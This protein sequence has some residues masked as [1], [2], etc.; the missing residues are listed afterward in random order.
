[1]L[2]SKAGIPNPSSYKTHSVNQVAF[3]FG[4]AGRAIL[5][6]VFDSEVSKLRPSFN[7]LITTS[8]VRFKP[9]RWR[10]PWFAKVFIM[11]HGPRAV[12]VVSTPSGQHSISIPCVPS[13]SKAGCHWLGSRF[14]CWAFPSVRLNDR[15]GRI[16][17]S[18]SMMFLQV[19]MAVKRWMEGCQAVLK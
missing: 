16:V 18:L 8:S 6:I 1:M 5:N 11:G 19:M 10:K 4:L 13:L 7:A 15:A 2:T 17:A 9:S 12:V 14:C 3:G